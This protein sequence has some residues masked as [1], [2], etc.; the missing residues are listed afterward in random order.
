MCFFVPK[1]FAL[2]LNPRRKEGRRL[3]HKLMS[4]VFVNICVTF[5]IEQLLKNFYLNFSVF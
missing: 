1:L 4:N 5:R 3:F 2:V